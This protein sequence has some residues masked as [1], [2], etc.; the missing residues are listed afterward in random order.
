MPAGTSHPTLRSSGR[1]ARTRPSSRVLSAACACGSGEVDEQHQSAGHWRHWP[2]LNAWAE[3]QAQSCAVLCTVSNPKPS[4]GL[5]ILPCLSPSNNLAGLARLKCH[6]PAV[7]LSQR[8]EGVGGE[9][10]GAV[11]LN[12]D[13]LLG[14][15]NVDC[16][17]K[18]GGH[19][20][21]EAMHNWRPSRVGG[22][23][24]DSEEAAAQ[25]LSCVHMNC[26]RTSAPLRITS[27]GPFP[28]LRTGGRL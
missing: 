20:Q 15:R 8:A 7:H 16:G 9:V 28:C 25:G 1:R 10:V 2:P 12:G 23:A 24:E 5:P 3:L 14:Q 21:L 11:H 27:A 17:R 19:A 22:H 13:V 18:V 4:P 6:P 26:T